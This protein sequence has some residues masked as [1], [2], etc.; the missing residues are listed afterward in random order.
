MSRPGTVGIVAEYNPFHNGHLYHLLETVERT[1]AGCVVAVMSGCFTQRGEPAA[2]DKWTRAAAA[3]ENGI[4]LVL[5][6]PFIYACNSA[7]SFARGAIRL[8]DQLGCIDSFSF[9]SEAGE[10][11]PLIDTARLLRQESPAFR[12]ALA[13]RSGQGLSF[14]AA[15]EAAVADCYGSGPASVLRDPNNILGVEY[16]KEWLAL[17]SPM[18]PVTIRRHGASHNA[19]EGT[20]TIQSAATIRRMLREPDGV[21]RA[22]VFVPDATKAHVFNELPD[23]SMIENQ[24]FKYIVYKI[25]NTPP[26]QIAGLLSA[27]EGLENRLAAAAES[28]RDLDSLVRRIKTKRYTETRIRRL[29]LH[30]LLDLQ[31]ADFQRMEAGRTLYARVL[32]FSPA[33]AA[34]LAHIRKSGSA[35]IPV[36]TNI[37]R[38]GR[39]EPLLQEIL[40]YDIRAAALYQLLC[41]HDMGRT[42]DHRQKPYNKSELGLVDG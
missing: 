42:S 22:A 5:E 9:G 23:G 19:G 36:I 33:G 26:R 14:P 31:R 6:L 1:G 32:G 4:D 40:S 28:G 25:M 18:R 11:E 29:L 37:N 13:D 39:D 3:V 15:R 30:L 34:L 20:E 12:A 17:G 27:G 10:L 7:E 35:S 8:L 41:G 24:L 16:L 2:A 38:Q 21:K